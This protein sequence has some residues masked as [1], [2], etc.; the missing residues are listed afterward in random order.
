M[1]K[2]VAVAMQK[3]GVGKQ[4]PVSTWLHI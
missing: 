1:G 2:I 3:G 4:Q